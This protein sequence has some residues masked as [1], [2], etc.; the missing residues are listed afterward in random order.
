MNNVILSVPL[1]T[2][3][4]VNL[5]ATIYWDRKSYLT[6]DIGDD[7]KI[8]NTIFIP[9]E[10]NFIKSIHGDKNAFIE[11]V[12]EIV[13]GYLKTIYLKNVALERKRNILKNFAFFKTKNNIPFFLLKRNKKDS[14]L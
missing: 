12:D 10:E 3:R 6:V 2:V 13:R 7:K 8:T 1:S 4:Y 11:T 14:F 5:K 9:V